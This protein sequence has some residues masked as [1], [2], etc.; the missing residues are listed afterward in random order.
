MTLVYSS[1]IGLALLVGLLAI[2]TVGLLRTQA[3]LLKTLNKLGV[4]L[5]EEES[6]APIVITPVGRSAAH[7]IVGANP[8]GDPVVK[9]VVTG[10]DPV[11]VSFLSTTCTSCSEFW[12]AIDSD[13]MMIHNARYRVLVVTLGPDEESPTRAMKLSRGD[14]DVIM[15]S[16]AW[17]RFEV[18]GA[19]YFVVVNPADGRIIGEGTAANMSALSTFLGDAA[20]D[21]RWDASR[22]SDRT[23]ADREKMVDDELRRAGLLPGDPRLYHD[24]DEAHG[25]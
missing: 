1:I 19:P 21:L 20:G 15:S 12:E 8:N 5:D 22:G 4:R 2:L 6:A 18:P 11:L 10:S 24:P 17:S 14:V 9:S 7:E 23:D 16:D 13:E 25:D 3:E